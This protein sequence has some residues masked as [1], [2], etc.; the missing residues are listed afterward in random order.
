MI[1]CRYCGER[2]DNE[3]HSMDYSHYCGSYYNQN[4][5]DEKFQLYIGK[6]HL[7]IHRYALFLL[8][9]VLKSYMR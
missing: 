5:V 6:N 3:T 8:L 7:E 2:F 4:V 1:E 9:K